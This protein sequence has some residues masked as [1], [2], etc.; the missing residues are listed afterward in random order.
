VVS[1]ACCLLRV[2]YKGFA[3][4]F[5]ELG[6]DDYAVLAATAMGVPTVVIIDRG[7][8]P[9][10]LA[11]DVWTVPFDRITNFV[12]WLYILEILYF[13][14][15]AMVKL[16]LLFFFLRIFPKPII[17]RILWATIVFD[18]LFG[19]AFAITGVF[20]CDPISHYWT[21]WDGEGTGKCVNINALAWTNAIISIVL[22]IWMLV[23]PLYEVFHLQLSWRSKI[24][25]AM[26]FLVG[27][28]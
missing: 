1:A 3:F 5:T 14:L 4:G 18:I 10:G 25:V 28:L 6:Y 16:T 22:D 7:I 9:N 2:F 19:V 8:V 11:Q 12:R 27:T 15:I 21:R 24:S 23:L 13:L 26:M 20:Q 17:R